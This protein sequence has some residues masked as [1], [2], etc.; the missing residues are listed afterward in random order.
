MDRAKQWIFM[1]NMKRKIFLKY[2]IK[3]IV[4]KGLKKNSKL[5]FTYRYYAFYQ[6]IKTP[7][8]STIG[9]VVNRCAVTGRAL[10]VKKK[11]HYSRFFFRT[12]AY[13][14]HLPGFKRASW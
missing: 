14:G 6:L 2:E 4:L 7:R 13:K 1:D 8:W 10:S 9:Q 5:P 3:K 12:E 11:T